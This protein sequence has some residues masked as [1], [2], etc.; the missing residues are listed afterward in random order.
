MKEFIGSLA[1]VI[2]TLPITLP[3]WF[4]GAAFRAVVLRDLWAWF[5]APVAHIAAPTIWI[6]MGLSL[7]LQQMNPHYAYKPASTSDK[8]LDN[9]LFR[10]IMTT[11]MSWLLGWFI[12]AVAR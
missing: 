11:G 4:A 1:A 8:T 2:L 10:G 12:Q 9:P 7:L 3:I 6:L 5:V